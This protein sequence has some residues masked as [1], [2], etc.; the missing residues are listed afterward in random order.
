MRVKFGIAIAMFLC[1][2]MQVFGQTVV[3]PLDYGLRE[4]KTGTERYGVL[5]KC[6][7]DAVKKSAKVTY[8]GI[9]SIE[10]EIPEKFTSIPLTSETDFAGCMLKVLNHQ[11]KSVYLYSMIQKT[12]AIE[13]PAR[14]IDK[15]D[16]LM[17][18]ELNNGTYLLVITDKN[19]WV[20]QRKGHDYGH[21]RKDVI[22]V[23]NGVGSNKPVMPYDNVQSQAECTFCKVDLSQK[24]IKNLNVVRDAR[25][26]AVT[27]I[28][29][30]EVQ[31]NLLLE[32]M[33]FTTPE[34]TG[35][36]DDR[37]IRIEN[38]TNVRFENLN[39]KGT[40]SATNHSGYAFNMN[41]IW[42]HTAHQV[43]A[44]GNWGVYGN[45]NMH[46]VLLE[47]CDLNRFDIHCY[48]RDITCKGCV[49]RN[50][51]NQFASVYG[52][53][54]FEGCTFSDFIPYLNGASYN[55]LVPVDVIFCSCIFNLLQSNTKLTCIAK[56]S[57]MGNKENKRIELKK[58]CLPNF[59]FRNCIVNL[60]NEL[61][62]WYLLDFGGAKDGIVLGYASSIS[63]RNVTING[64]ALLDIAN[65]KFETDQLL[66]INFNK[67]YKIFNG[68][69][70]MFSL[71]PVTVGKNATVKCNRKNVAHK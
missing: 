42:N 27:N 6:H 67:V 40:Y 36:L 28:F 20:E 46:K 21:I 41:N 52:K 24:V 64:V 31:N 54:Y 23:R 11:K 59:S 29:R 1:C 25:S 50:L 18:P 65:V 32:N 10:I 37:L 63:M 60:D 57:G 61:K 34:G 5:L 49:F 44:I 45:N 12:K 3:N 7:Q 53:V 15:A 55:A 13:V 62:Q 4:A 14:C 2:M 66:D 35:L 26:T 68:K 16:F 71:H 48:G 43:T 51:Y 9:G 56:I 19:P 30:I 69:K 22:L 58:K 17:L 39:V 47:D 70:E 33:N 8:A 38:C